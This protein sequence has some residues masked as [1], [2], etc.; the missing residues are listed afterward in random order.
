M[1]KSQLYTCLKCGPTIGFCGPHADGHAFNMGGYPHNGF[2]KAI[3]A[4]KCSIPD[5]DYNALPE[6]IPNRC[7]ALGCPEQA[8]RYGFCSVHLGEGNLGQIDD[9]ETLGEKKT[10]KPTRPRKT[11]PTS[12]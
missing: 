11:V 7:T 8:L 6:Y 3:E 2:T 9:R 12:P 5:C 10:V 4:V 1:E